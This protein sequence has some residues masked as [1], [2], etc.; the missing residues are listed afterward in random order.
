[1]KDPWLTQ[2]HALFNLASS[3]DP[4]AKD[5]LFRQYL[6]LLEA[7]ARKHLSP[8]VR[9]LVDTDD[10]VQMTLIDGLKKL[11]TFEYRRSGAFLAYLRTVALNHIRSKGREQ[12]RK[13][14]VSVPEDALVAFGGTVKPDDPR[15]F[16][17]YEEVLSS[18]DE[19][20][21]DFITVA[22]EFRPTNRQLAEMFDIDSS[23]AARMRLKRLLAKIADG[24]RR[25][26]S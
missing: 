22:L 25:K 3:G 15:V 17:I 18:L 12:G 20:D 19:K 2:S 6:P 8:S 5:E 24:M 23:D 1:M 10:I 4:S 21:R 9:R 7:W 11:Q 26:M 16:R 14:E 13:P